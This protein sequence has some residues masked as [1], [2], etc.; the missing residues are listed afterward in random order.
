MGEHNDHVLTSILGMSEDEV[1][2][3]IIEGVLE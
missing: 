3:L 1:N 2:E